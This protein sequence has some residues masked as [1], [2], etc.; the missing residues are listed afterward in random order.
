[1]LRSPNRC[2]HAPSWDERAQNVRASAVQLA[3]LVAAEQHAREE[4][5][6]V[7][8]EFLDFLDDFRHTAVL[9]PLDDQG[10]LWSAELG[11]IR[12]ILAFSDDEALARFALAREE[13]E[14][15]VG[16]RASREWVYHK[17]LGRRL[18]ESVIPAVGRPCG[19]ALDAGSE[20]GRVLPPVA[21][22]V[23]DKAT[24]DAFTAHGEGTR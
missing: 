8:R 10:G 21:G 15:D 3:D 2:Q 24:V 14:M 5:A 23:P 12:W 9:V 20:D 22:I 18:L 6:A 16:S 17:V 1:L 13:S 11:G 19:V 7:K 4:A